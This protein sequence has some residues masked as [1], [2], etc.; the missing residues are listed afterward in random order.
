MVRTR[1]QN[2]ANN[3]E[4]IIRQLQQAVAKLQANLQ[5]ANKTVAL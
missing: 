4:E 1:S 5:Q 3:N 2:M